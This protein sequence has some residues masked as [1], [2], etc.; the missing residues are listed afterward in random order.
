VTGDASWGF[1]TDAAV[2]A[3]GPT[4]RQLALKYHE[5]EVCRS[6]LVRGTR[7]YWGLGDAVATALGDAVV[8]VPDLLDV[9]AAAES[10]ISAS[11]LIPECSAAHYG[12]DPD[13]HVRAA[14]QRRESIDEL[15]RPIGEARWAHVARLYEVDA[16]AARCTTRVAAPVA[17]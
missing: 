9:G 14:A 11:N 4:V 17:R 13:A 1:W 15:M 6:R 2:Y 7:L 5:T 16:Q 3:L 10:A 8:L 12:H